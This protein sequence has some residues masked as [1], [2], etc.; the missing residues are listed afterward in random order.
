MYSQETSASSKGTSKTAP[1][2]QNTKPR[3]LFAAIIKL[4]R[5]QCDHSK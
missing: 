4:T 3:A 5:D 1:F 2:D